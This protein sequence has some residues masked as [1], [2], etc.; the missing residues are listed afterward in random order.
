VNQRIPL[1]AADSP[2][3]VR[4][5]RRLRRLGPPL[6]WPVWAAGVA[7]VSALVGAWLET[8]SPPA[9]EVRLDAQGYHIAGQ[10]LQDQG[11][12][13]YQDPSGAALVIQRGSGRVLAA[14]STNLNGR[15]MLGRCVEIQGADHEDCT[16][17]IGSATIQARDDRTPSGWHRRYSDGQTVDIGVP[18]GADT[19]VPFA[20]G[21]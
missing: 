8:A 9:V 13:S 19:P 1:G 21:R 2:Y 16:F 17:T 20:V 6:G 15:H 10:L 12:G 18:G 5:F 14:A 3:A 7:L 4:R 11:D